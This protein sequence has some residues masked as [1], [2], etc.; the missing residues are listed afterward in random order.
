MPLQFL[1]V[2]PG[3]LERYPTRQASHQIAS[4]GI[5]S[6]LH[7]SFLSVVVVGVLRGLAGH[8]LCVLTFPNGFVVDRE[9][10]TVELVVITVEVVVHLLGDEP[11]L[12][13]L[14]VRPME[15]SPVELPSGVGPELVESGICVVAYDKVAV[16]SSVAHLNEFA[17]HEVALM[18]VEFHIEHSADLGWFVVIGLCGVGREPEGVSDEVACVVGV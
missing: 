12:A 16:A 13:D 6:E 15:K 8:A 2:I 17:L 7:L 1:S 14:G 10:T 9:D 11:L 3:S 5:E 4:F 18:V